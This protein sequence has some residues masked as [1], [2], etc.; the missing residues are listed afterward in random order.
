MKVSPARLNE[1]RELRDIALALLDRQGMNVILVDRDRQFKIRQHHVGDLK[2]TQ[3]API[4]A[5]ILDVY[6]G[7]KVFS[8]RWNDVDAI[9]VVSFKPGDWR[10]AL[11]SSAMPPSGWRIEGF[12]ESLVSDGGPHFHAGLSVRPHIEKF[13]NDQTHVRH[14]VGSARA[15]VKN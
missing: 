6:H 15:P 13:L 8:V 5:Q 3:S 7:R 9:D 1:A 14:F 2:I 12:P 4:G 10:Q 11:R